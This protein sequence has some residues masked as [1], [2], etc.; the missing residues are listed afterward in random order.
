MPRKVSRCIGDHFQRIHLYLLTYIYIS[1]RVLFLP[2]RECVR[3]SAAR[4]P[5]ERSSSRNSS[6][7]YMNTSRGKFK[8]QHWFNWQRGR[9]LERMHSSGTCLSE[10]EFRFRRS[11]SSSCNITNGKN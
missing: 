5:V 9:S 10:R 7:D 2:L 8:P 6:C 1:R 11:M 4:E 3:T